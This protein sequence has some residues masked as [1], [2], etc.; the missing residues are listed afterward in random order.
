VQ[1]ATLHTQMSKH[2]LYASSLTSRACVQVPGSIAAVACERHFQHMCVRH[3]QLQL[4]MPAA[5]AMYEVGLRVLSALRQSIG[6][7]SALD[8]ETLCPLLAKL[9]VDNQAHIAVRCQSSR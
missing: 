3:L 1:L 5:D 2:I 9:A 8:L 6:E 7:A 4:A